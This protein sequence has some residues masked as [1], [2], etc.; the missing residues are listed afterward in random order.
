VILRLLRKTEIFGGFEE[1]K[2][3]KT[4]SKKNKFSFEKNKNEIEFKNR[5]ILALLFM[6]VYEI[7]HFW[8]YCRIYSSR[9]TFYISM[10]SFMLKEKSFQTRV[11]EILCFF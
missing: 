5:E 7:D 3:E 10:N 8:P 11:V 2:R 9:R 1:K 6:E 4:R